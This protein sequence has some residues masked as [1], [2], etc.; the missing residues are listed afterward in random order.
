M[1]TEKATSDPQIGL[2]TNLG[3][4]GGAA[5]SRKRGFV[6]VGDEQN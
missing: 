6:G 2:Y 3:W 4:W 5:G 1:K